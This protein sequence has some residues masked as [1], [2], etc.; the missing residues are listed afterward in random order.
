MRN[1]ILQKKIKRTKALTNIKIV[2]LI[3]IIIGFIIFQAISMK[4][5][6]DKR[7]KDEKRQEQF[8]KFHP[9]LAPFIPSDFIPIDSYVN[10]GFLVPPGRDERYIV[11]NRTVEEA[12]AEI[13]PLFRERGLRPQKS[14]ISESEPNSRDLYIDATRHTTANQF[15]RIHIS[16]QKEPNGDVKVQYNERWTGPMS[17]DPEITTPSQTLVKLSGTGKATTEEFITTGDWDIY[18]QYDCSNIGK[19]GDFGFSSYYHGHGTSSKYE[20]A[21]LGMY[22][23]GNKDSGIE[24]A[25]NESVI[26]KTHFIKISSP[27]AW[28]IEVKG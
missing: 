12:L 28:E 22:Q 8:K 26:Q 18:W 24:P 5:E 27:C 21:E 1:T 17:Y 2:S 3:L 13:I 7:L 15:P 4:I 25:N 6:E 20:F 14:F 16:V 10:E 23:S 9:L 19:K 11:H